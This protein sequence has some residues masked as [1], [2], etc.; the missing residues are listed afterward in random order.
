MTSNFNP[1]NSIGPSSSM[2]ISAR[3]ANA[4]DAVN[5]KDEELKAY[6]VRY[7]DLAG[8]LKKKSV[9]APTPKKSNPVKQV[10]AIFGKEALINGK[11]YKAGDRVQDARIVAVEATQIRVEWQGREKI[12]APLQV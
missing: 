2:T 9:F 4:V 12:F 10:A 3:I 1:A 7:T 6:T 11:W 8:E 5:C